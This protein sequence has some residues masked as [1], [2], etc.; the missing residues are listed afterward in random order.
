MRSQMP[1]QP[2]SVTAPP[3]GE[4]ARDSS[5]VKVTNVSKSFKSAGNS[6]KLVCD[7]VCLDVQEGS[8]TSIVGPS[9]CGKSTLLN[10]CAGLLQP[11]SGT[12]VVNGTRIDGPL[13]GVG[14]VTQDANLLPWKTVE[15]NIG[16]PLMIQKVPKRERAAEVERWLELVGLSGFA[17]HYPAQ[18]SGGMQKRTSIARSLIYAPRFVLMDEP[19]GPLD[20]MT[21][22]VLQQELLNLWQQQASSVTL[23]FVT[24]DLQEAIALSDRVVVM[25]RHPGR[26]KEVVDIDI[27]RPRRVARIAEHDR[28]GDLHKT[29]WRLLRDDLAIE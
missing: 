11:D 3:A 26:I 24:H 19:F 29:L 5:Y 10:M 21:R 22:V 27:P 28:Y 8:F 23:I 20:A 7:D 2:V 25:S 4:D 13:H 15:Q 17:R 1:Q 16:L 6:E 14:Y 9:G 18:L 12:I